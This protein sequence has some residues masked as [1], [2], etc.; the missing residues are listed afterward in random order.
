MATLP[1]GL[2]TITGSLSSP[3][4]CSLPVPIRAAGSCS[5]TDTIDS[6][7]SA[8]SHPLLPCAPPARSS[9][10]ARFSTARTSKMTGMPVS[11]ATSAMPL[12]A[13]FATRSK[14]AVSPRITAPRQMTPSNRPERAKRRATSGISNAPGTH[15]TSMSSSDTP[16]AVRPASA[17][18][19][20][21]RVMTSLKRAAT[22][23]I[24]RPAP[25]GL[26][27]EDVHRSPAPSRTGASRQAVEQVTHLLPLRAQVLRCSRA[28]A[29]S[30]S[31]SRAEMESPCPSSPA[32][33]AGLFVSSRIVRTPRSTRIC[34]PIPYSRGSAGNPSSVL[35]STVSR[36]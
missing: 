35:A 27:L 28:S 5:S 20:S 26:T 29:R 21:L 6:T 31:G 18:S 13:S 22:T 2:S 10:W 19:T 8:A 25:C 17:P 34:A 11:R 30:R 36:P 23:A 1:Q 9:A 14:C 3:T 24:R 32:R 15:A 12:A 16:R 4:V 7:A 33:L